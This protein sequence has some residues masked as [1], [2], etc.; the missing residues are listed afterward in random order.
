[1][2]KLKLSLSEVNEKLKN[3]EAEIS[4]LRKIIDNLQNNSDSE[5]VEI[6]NLKYLKA[7]K[8][9]TTCSKCGKKLIKGYSGYYDVETKKVY[10]SKCKNSLTEKKS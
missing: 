10:C 6:K 9:T 8:R 3:I 1:M 4:S 5:K 2:E 7:L